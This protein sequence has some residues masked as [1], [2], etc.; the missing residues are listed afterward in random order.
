ML[1]VPLAGYAADTPAATTPALAP[2]PVKETE[3]TR[4]TVEQRI[5]SLHEKLQITAA[6]EPKWSN[7][8]KSMRHSAATMEKLIAEHSAKDPA[9]QTALDDLR[10]YTK[11]SQAH[12]DGLKSLEESFESLYK[13]MPVPQKKIADAVFQDA[14]HRG[15]A[16][17]L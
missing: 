6:E 9:T 13:S 17:R 5:A 16:A 4:E 11:F 14:G 8:A 7:V 10:L 12:V 15:G 1:S 3:T 2:A